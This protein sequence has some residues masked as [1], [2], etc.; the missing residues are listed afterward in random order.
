[1][2]VDDVA[3]DMW[4]RNT[5]LPVAL[6]HTVS[7]AVGGKLYVIGGQV[8]ARGAVPFVDT[9]YVYPPATAVWM[10]RAPMPTQ[11]GGGAG[12]VINPSRIPSP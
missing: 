9:V 2:Q 11:R 5:P 6:N 7:A 3:T 1:M 12:A 10:T 4:R 8:S